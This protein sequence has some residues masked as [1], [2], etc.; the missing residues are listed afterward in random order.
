M[1]HR[2]IAALLESFLTDNK[3]YLAL[4]I[5]QDN[6]NNIIRAQRLQSDD[7]RYIIYQ[8]LSGLKYLHSCGIIHGDLKPSDVGINK[9]FS[10]KIIDLNVER[11]KEAD[12]VLTKWYGKVGKVPRL[13]SEST[14]FLL[15][16][17]SQVPLARELVRVEDING[18]S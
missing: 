16:L 8:L 13:A 2:N 3:L 15:S 11:P 14:T 6:L 18:E 17:L 4:E 7:I 10:I 9:D 12:Y 1:R 5:M